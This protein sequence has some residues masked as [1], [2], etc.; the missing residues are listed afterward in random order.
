[1]IGL[2]DAAVLVSIKDLLEGV[3]LM[4]SIWEII[5]LAKMPAFPL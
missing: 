4:N 2:A 3:V 5:D 1:V